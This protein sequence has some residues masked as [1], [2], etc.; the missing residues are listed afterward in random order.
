MTE[1]VVSWLTILEAWTAVLD[2]A[3]C[4]WTLGIMFA[5]ITS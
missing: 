1:A 5:S 3:I 4:V 2:F